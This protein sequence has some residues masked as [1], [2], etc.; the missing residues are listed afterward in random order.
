MLSFDLWATIQGSLTLRPLYNDIPN[1]K[2]R[3]DTIVSPKRP[4]ASPRSTFRIRI[5]ILPFPFFCDLRRRFRT[6]DGS[7]G[8]FLALS[9]DDASVA[10]DGED[11]GDDD[12][13][14][15]SDDDDDDNS[16]PPDEEE[17]RDVVE[18]ESPILRCLSPRLMYELGLIIRS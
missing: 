9:N 18:K 17:E 10:N 5:K 6:N 3:N 15:N 4:I 8:S 11:D 2:V 16:D 7:K 13:D 1:K 14:G 12:A